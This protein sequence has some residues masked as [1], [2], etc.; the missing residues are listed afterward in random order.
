MRV[1][2]K[3]YKIRGFSRFRKQRSFLTLWDNKVTAKRNVHNQLDRA[4]RHQ[5][6][7]SAP[8]SLHQFV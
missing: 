4:L 3:A 7:F 1:T 6:G 5:R 2:G 8:L